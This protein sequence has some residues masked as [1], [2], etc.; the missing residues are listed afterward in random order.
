MWEAIAAV[1]E[2]C[3]K[4]QG[5]SSASLSSNSQLHIELFLS[6]VTTKICLIV[7]NSGLPSQ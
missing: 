5:K 3:F 1:W 2:D 4:L 6:G 7:H